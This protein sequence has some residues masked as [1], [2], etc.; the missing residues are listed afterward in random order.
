[1]P[2]R[3]EAKPHGHANSRI[4]VAAYDAGHSWPAGEVYL[5]DEVW[6]E[7]FSL[8]A[9]RADDGPRVQL[10]AL[11]RFLVCMSSLEQAAQRSRGGKKRSLQDKQRDTNSTG[12]PSAILNT[13]STSGMGV[14]PSDVMSPSWGGEAS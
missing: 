14:P 3:D 8:S 13:P 6:D 4:W 1:M 12:R 10:A 7:S 5:A 2:L 9:Q 11:R